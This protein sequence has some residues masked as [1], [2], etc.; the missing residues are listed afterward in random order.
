MKYAFA[1]LA[2]ALLIVDSF[3]RTLSV[4]VPA[5]GNTATTSDTSSCHTMSKT[6]VALMPGWEFLKDKVK[7]EYGEYTDYYVNWEERPGFEAFVCSEG[8]SGMNGINKN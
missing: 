8:Q 2:V 6:E 1:A 4:P 5:S 3:D 7:A